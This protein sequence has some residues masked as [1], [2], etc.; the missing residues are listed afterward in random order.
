M[1]PKI[2]APKDAA[3]SASAKSREEKASRFL[4]TVNTNYKPKSVSDGADLMRKLRDVLNQL[5]SSEAELA[6]IVKW[7]EGPRDFGETV[8]E[9]KSHFALEV[10]HHPQGSRVHAHALLSF[11]HT[12]K[13]HIDIPEARRWFN[14]HMKDERVK[15]FYVHVKAVSTGNFDVKKYIKKGLWSKEKKPTN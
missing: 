7:L 10:G 15:R 2:R 1:P 8:T 3:A 11:K 5:L 13:M 4:M 6:K 9:V 12:S 14:A